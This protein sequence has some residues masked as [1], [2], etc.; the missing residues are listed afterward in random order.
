MKCCS[1][2]YHL[3]GSAQSSSCPRTLARRTEVGKR[4]STTLL[5]AETATISRI[6]NPNRI[7]VAFHL[8]L[9]SMGESQP[10]NFPMRLTARSGVSGKNG[11]FEATNEGAHFPLGSSLRLRTNFG[12]LALKPQHSGGVSGMVQRT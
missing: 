8:F 5:D 12:M 10:K 11:G 9:N 1:R 3:T 7:R 2:R 4:M 6:T